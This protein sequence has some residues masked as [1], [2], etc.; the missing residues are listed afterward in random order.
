MTLSYDPNR[1]LPQ[2]KYLWFLVM[3]YCVVILMSNWFDARLIRLY[4]FAT[5]AG[6]LVFPLTFLLSDLI[7]EVYGYEQARRAIWCGFLFNALFIIYGQIV[8]HLPSPIYAIDS[9]ATFDAILAKNSRI[10]I[11]SSIS[12]ICSEPLNA[13]TIAK[14]KILTG[15]KYLALRFIVSTFLASGLDSAIFATLAFVGLMSN[16]NLLTLMLTMWGLKVAIEIIGLPVSI[17]LTRLLKKTEM[18]DIFDKGT[19]FDLFSLEVH[20]TAKN[21]RYKETF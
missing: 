18:L 16:Y 14:L 1:P 10:F 17:S 4:I 5:D 3:S 11:A 9:N 7:T 20:Y 19:N 6:T 2:P 12:Y 13:F 8:T 21:N 15:G